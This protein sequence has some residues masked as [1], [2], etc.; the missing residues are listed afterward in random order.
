MSINQHSLRVKTILTTLALFFA[1]CAAAD[2]AAQ[3]VTAM[4]ATKPDTV[5]LSVTTDGDYQIK[6]FLIKHRSDSD[7]SIR[8]Q[9]NLAKLSSTLDGN[10][11][12]LA[13]LTSFVQTLMADTLMHVN[14]V[15]IIGFSSPDGSWTMNETLAKNRAM[16]FKNY[17]DT[18]YGFS[19]KF[20]V[21]TSWVAEDWEMC[22]ALVAQSQI[23]DKEDVLRILDGAWTSEQ[24]EE[25]LKKMP[26]AWGYMKQRILPS[27][28]R[29]ELTITYG[30]GTVVEQRMMIRKPQP[31]P[32]PRQECCDPCMI[33][34]ESVTGIIVEMDDPGVDFDKKELKHE[35]RKTRKEFRELNHDYKKLEKELR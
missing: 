15:E 25:A 10:S 4:S 16:D 29:V 23:P 2:A 19:S 11:Q 7:Y 22:R 33:I 8:Y 1:C 12:E 17:V 14:G 3:G 27:L 9:I 35:R 32:Q 31:V 24:K 6:R 30:E 5:V 21:T 26:L 28:R 13:N 18:K 20:D 34:D